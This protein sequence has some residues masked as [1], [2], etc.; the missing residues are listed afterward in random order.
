MQEH[1]DPTNDLTGLERQLSD[2][3]P[4]TAGLSPDQMLFAAGRASGRAG[5][6]RLGWLAS[7]C[8]AGLSA[9]LGLALVQERQ[10]SRGLLAQV[11]ESR[12]GL[13]IDSRP[14]PDGDDYPSTTPPAA[15][16]YLAARLAMAQGVDRWTENSA[17]L[18]MASPPP[19]GRRVLKA[20]SPSEMIE[21]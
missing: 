7:G 3:R 10:V 8:L 11:H 15:S 5:A 20:H 9:I 4:A 14:L 19:P 21:P 17:D 16:S 6:S 13:E 18:P 12:P 1:P 2:W